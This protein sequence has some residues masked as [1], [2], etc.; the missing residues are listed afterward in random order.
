MGMGISGKAM[1]E[2]LLSKN[3]VVSV[4]DKRKFQDLPLE[5]QEYLRK[6]DIFYEGGEQSNE[7]MA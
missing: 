1:L 5:D 4:T 2:F 3:I 7:F 6:H